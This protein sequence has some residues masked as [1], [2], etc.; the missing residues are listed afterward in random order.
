MNPDIMHIV[1]LLRANPL[2][3]GG[4]KPPAYGT[5]RHAWLAYGSGAAD[6]KH[7]SIITIGGHLTSHDNGCVVPLIMRIPERT[8]Q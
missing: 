4:A 6:G 1:C 8:S 3:N 2:K 7:T 5:V